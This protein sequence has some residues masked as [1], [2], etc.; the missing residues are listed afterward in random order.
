MHAAIV[1]RRPAKRLMRPVA[2]ASASGAPKASASTTSATVQ[3]SAA[4]SET[5]S[6]RVKDRIAVPSAP[7]R[8]AEGRQTDDGEQRLE[9]H[10]HREIDHADH[11]VDLEAAIGAALDEA[12]DMKQLVGGDLRGE[13]GAEQQEDELAGHGRIDV[14]QCRRQYDVAEHLPAGQPEA[15]PRFE[16]ASRNGVEPGADDLDR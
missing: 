5:K 8:P 13:R 7:P 4:N 11:R 16:L 15:L 12:G 1:Q 9:R 2:N 3:R 14:A 10:R 6:M